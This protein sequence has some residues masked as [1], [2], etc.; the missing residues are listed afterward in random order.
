MNAITKLQALVSEIQSVQGAEAAAMNVAY[1]TGTIGVPAEY[2]ERVKEI[3]A[4]E[5][6]KQWACEVVF[7]THC[8]SFFS[9]N[10]E[11][12]ARARMIE[13]AENL[14]FSDLLKYLNAKEVTPDDDAKAIAQ[15]IVSGTIFAAEAGNQYHTVKETLADPEYMGFV[16]NTLANSETLQVG[17]DEVMDLIKVYT[18]RYFEIL[19]A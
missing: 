15:S 14:G 11:D 12:L 10:S 8:F 13:I 5:F 9:T 16:R 4:D 3:L 1:E 17:V 6:F 18:D 2:V 19:P 7:G